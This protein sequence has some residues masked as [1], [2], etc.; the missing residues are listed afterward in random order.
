[1]ELA[2]FLRPLFQEGRM[3]V[4]N[5]PLGILSGDDEAAA[6]LERAYRTVALD[7]SGPAL[8]M[9]LELALAAARLVYQ[10]AWYLLR[11]EEP[12]AVLAQR[13]VLKSTPTRPEHHLSADV[14]LRYLPAVYR[15]ARAS[16]PAD[17]LTLFLAQLLRTW[18]LSGVLADLEDEPLTPPDFGGH[19]GLLMLYAERLARHEKPAWIPTTGPGAEYVALVRQELGKNPLL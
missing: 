12:D 11:H 19:P 14:T 1:M 13:L 15:R 2:E 6:V 4:G 3:L 18:P 16:D 5:A 8:A 7:L 10:A 17:S 9:D